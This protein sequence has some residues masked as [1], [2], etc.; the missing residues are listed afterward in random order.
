MTRYRERGYNQ[1]K[2][3]AD[4]VAGLLG[5]PI[6]NG[7]LQRHFF[8]R[9]QVGLGKAERRANVAGAFQATP[10]H[11]AGRHLILVDDV[12]TTGATLQACGQALIAGGAVAVYGLTVTAARE[13][14]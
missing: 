11:V 2:A 1:A 3:L 8:T 14:N 6:P 13:Q 5:L 4:E 10:E 7:A 12:L 9:S